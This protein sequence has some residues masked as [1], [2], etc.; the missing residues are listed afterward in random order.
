MG[1]AARLNVISDCSKLRAP[2]GLPGDADRSERGK[3]ATL[4]NASMQGRGTKSGTMPESALPASIG[5]GEGWE[6]A[7]NE[8]E[9]NRQI[10]RLSHLLTTF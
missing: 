8:M 4:R 9:M 3:L 5:L 1:A 6:R 10:V 7:S 2:M